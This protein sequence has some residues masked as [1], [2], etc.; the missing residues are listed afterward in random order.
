MEYIMEFDKDKDG[1][2]IILGSLNKEEF[3]NS[4]IW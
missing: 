3:I 2:L 4:F 1:N